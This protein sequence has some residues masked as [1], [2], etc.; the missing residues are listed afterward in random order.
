MELREV[1]AFLMLCEELHFTRAAA[2]LRVAQSAISQALQRLEKEVGV[3]LF[4]RTQR[5]VALTAAGASFRKHAL[6]ALHELEQAALEARRAAA[7]QTGKL[8]LRFN[9]IAGLTIVP[10]VL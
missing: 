6:L 10:L 4:A 7:G 5:R 9:L 2:R 8:V 3:P 1:R